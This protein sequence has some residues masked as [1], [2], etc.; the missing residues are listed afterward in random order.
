MDPAAASL[1]MPFIFS[2]IQSSKFLGPNGLQGY[3]LNEKRN[4]VENIN[5]IGS[6]FFILLIFKFFG[7]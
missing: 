3:A 7:F 5:L 6:V 1:V 2:I 4:I